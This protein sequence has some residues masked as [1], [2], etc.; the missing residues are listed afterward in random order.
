MK[1]NFLKASAFAGLALS[2]LVLASCGEN[3]LTSTEV[4]NP[5]TTEALPTTTELP[6][7]SADMPETVEITDLDGKVFTVSET[8]DANVVTKALLLSALSGVQAE[9]SPYAIA[10]DAILLGSITAE[11]SGVTGTITA[12]VNASAAASIGKNPYTAFDVTK[13][14]TDEEIE[15]AVAEVNNIAAVATLKGGVN[16]S[17]FVINEK[18]PFFTKN[19]EALEQIK[20][21]V[22]ALAKEYVDADLRV[23]LKDNTAY[24]EFFAHIPDM[25]L[26][27]VKA[28]VESDIEFT[29]K[30]EG[31]FTKIAPMATTVLNDYQN[32]SLINFY[33]KYVEMID[34]G[35]DAKVKLAPLD[36]SM[37]NAEFFES[38]VYEMVVSFVE[39]LGIEISEINDGVATFSLDITGAKVKSFLKQIGQDKIATMA[40]AL[41]PNDVSLA[42]IA[43]NVDLA[44]ARLNH[45]EVYTDAIETIGNLV[46]A[47]AALQMPEDETLPVESV[48]GSLGLAIDVKYDAD[49]NAVAEPKEGIEYTIAD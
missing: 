43:L 32:L 2:A 4:V 39:M 12:N 33:N 6:T 47:Y 19:P 16:F 8:K 29:P 37:V 49:V 7:T 36:L 13:D 45:F 10:L 3:A 40:N 31:V 9:K 1:K 38:E 28:K 23:F 27:V 24:G 22:E 35:D 17:D 44:K 34:F 18:D 46:L 42:K 41:L 15:K 11:G 26:E 30:A 14:L 48:K 5:T 21:Q 25:I 20:P